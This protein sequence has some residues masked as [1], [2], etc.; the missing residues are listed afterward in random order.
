MKENEER[1]VAV[2]EKYAL[3]GTDS[4]TLMKHK[5]KGHTLERRHHLRHNFR[6]MTSLFSLRNC[7]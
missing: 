1:Y 4:F 5:Y 6:L 7:K 2:A 3:D